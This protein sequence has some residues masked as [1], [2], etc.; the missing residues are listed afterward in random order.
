MKFLV[1]E[2][3]SR[4]IVPAIAA[5]FPDS[6][7][8]TDLSLHTKD[9]SAIWDFAKQNGFSILTKDSDFN[10]ILVMKQFPPKIVWI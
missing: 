3:I 2:N 7:H 1:D 4:R 5:S 6:R 8:V 10:E 9:D